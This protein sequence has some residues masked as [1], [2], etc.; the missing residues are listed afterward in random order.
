MEGGGIWA[1]PVF[2]EPRLRFGVGVDEAVKLLGDTP[3]GLRGVLEEYRRESF[4]L[5][6]RGDQGVVLLKEGYSKLDLLKALLQVVLYCPG[7]IL[8]EE[9]INMLV[10]AKELFGK[11]V[12]ANAA[13]LTSGCIV[14]PQL[15]RRSNPALKG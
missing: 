6:W 12:A 14:V 5:V 1:D 3:G 9:L 13:S 11:W 10:Q 15:V 7:N 4:A 8:H 2:W